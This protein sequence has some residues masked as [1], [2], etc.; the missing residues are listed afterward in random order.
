MN[1][2]FFLMTVL[3]A[4]LVA[5]VKADQRFVFDF[6]DHMKQM[7]ELHEEMMEMHKNMSSLFSGTHKTQQDATQI[8]ALENSQSKTFDVVIT[9][10][11]T[12]Q[13]KPEASFSSD[14]AQKEL[15]LE[16]PLVNGTVII[17]NRYNPIYRCWLINVTHN[18][19]QSSDSDNSKHVARM[20][21]SQTITS[22]AAFDLTSVPEISFDKESKTLTIAFKTEQPAQQ[23]AKTVVP[24][25]IK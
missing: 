1:K 20:T 21:S 22:N 8:S 25:A 3:P 23:K 4:T 19:E 6:S 16:V 2:R 9:N 13:D 18:H 10:V 11:E 24:V 7:Q 17:N 12:K 15:S 5:G 14:S